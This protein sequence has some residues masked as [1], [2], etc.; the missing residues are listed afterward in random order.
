[1]KS[2]FTL[3]TDAFGKISHLTFR[4]AEREFAV[5]LRSV[6]EIASYAPVTPL[7]GAPPCIHGAFNLR[8]E[9]I[10]VVDLAVKLALPPGVPTKRTCI[11]VIELPPNPDDLRVVGILIDVVGQVVDLGT[12]DIRSPP[13]VGGWIRPEFLLGLGN[14]ESRWIPLLD[15]FRILTAQEAHAVVTLV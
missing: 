4:V 1:M 14:I 10:A 6:R 8:G 2:P 3:G 9:A 11:L 7:P 15:V 12:D 5:P 13:P